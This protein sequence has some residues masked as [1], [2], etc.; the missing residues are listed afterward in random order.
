MISIVWALLLSIQPTFAAQGTYQ[1]R[2]NMDTPVHRIT[3]GPIKS[4]THL[5]QDNEN[6]RYQA[7]QKATI[8]GK[9]Y[10]PVIYTESA[11]GVK[12]TVGNPQSSDVHVFALKQDKLE[13]LSATGE[14]INAITSKNK[15]TDVKV[16]KN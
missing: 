13:E 5:S 14:A 4:L 8:D 9:L 15:L 12:I 1:Y 6:L 10:S 3:F 7:D 2:G 16:V 11:T